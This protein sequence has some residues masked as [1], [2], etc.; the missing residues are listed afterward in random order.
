MT[1][2]PRRPVRPSLP[3]S[4]LCFTTL[5]HV[6]PLRPAPPD[7]SPPRPSPP[8]PAPPLP[9]AAP[10][11]ASAPGRRQFRVRQDRGPPRRPQHPH[12]GL[13]GTGVH[14]ARGD[15]REQLRWGQVG[16]VVL[17]CAVPGHGCRL[18]AHLA[19][20]HRPSSV[21]PFYC[22][23][24]VSPLTPWPRH[25]LSPSSFLDFRFSSISN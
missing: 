6:S 2:I 22:S 21:D 8:V 16:L 7:P 13:V 4:L 15:A 24:S 17:S 5:P 18:P 12:R 25:T 20:A 11:P 14:H 10:A 3:L 19:S 23:V 1:H 9:A